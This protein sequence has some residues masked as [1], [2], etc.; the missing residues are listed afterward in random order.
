MLN[1]ELRL[2]YESLP[3]ISLA[4]SELSTARNV[5]QC[6]KLDRELLRPSR[7]FGRAARGLHFCG[8]HRTHAVRH[9]RPARSV[10]KR[11]VL[12]VNLDDG[13]LK[14]YGD[15]NILVLLQHKT[16]IALVVPQAGDLEF[17]RR[18]LNATGIYSC[19]CSSSSRSSR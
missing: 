14:H 1:A 12:L 4:S 5:P 13:L 8:E 17:S 2:T 7:P 16:P 3:E 9:I 6:P 11:I 10:H 15:Y 19:R 18:D